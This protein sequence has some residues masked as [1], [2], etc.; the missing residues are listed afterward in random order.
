MF[1]HKKVFSVALLFMTVLLLVACGSASSD[2][3]NTLDAVDVQIILTDYG[4]ESSVDVF[5]AGVPYHF[6]VVN[7]GEVEHEIMLMP[8]MATEAMLKLME[9][10]D[11]DTDD[12]HEEGDA[13]AEDDEAH[14]DDGDSHGE[15]EDDHAHDMLM[16]EGIVFAVVDAHNLQPGD[17]ASFEYTFTE[18]T[19]FGEI[20]FACHL[21]GHYEE[22]MFLPLWVQ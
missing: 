12:S 6:T 2:Q 4:T 22:G 20:E 18:A 3:T 8:P 13:H 7:E 15:G 9:G 21:E 16:E 14:A 11:H 10:N 19:G 17:S 5:E 1:F